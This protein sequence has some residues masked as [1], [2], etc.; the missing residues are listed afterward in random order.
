M[1]IVFLTT[2]S[3]NSTVCM[4]MLGKLGWDLGPA[5]S[6]AEH[7]GIR[8]LNVNTMKGNRFYEVAAAKLLND[9]R[10]PWAIK[11]PRFVHTL[12]N[13]KP[14]LKKFQPLLLWVTKRLDYTQKSMERRFKLPSDLAAKRYNWC[15]IHFDDWPYAKLKL[16]VDQISA[17][18]RLFDSDRV[19]K[20]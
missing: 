7:P 6:Y 16:D 13:W 12:L 15:Q 20:H 5:D 4:R 11:D 19:Y 18:V 2:G 3:A 1:N 9:L 8:A 14:V 10:E 17:A